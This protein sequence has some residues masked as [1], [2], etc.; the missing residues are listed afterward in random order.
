LEILI[1]LINQR[2]QELQWLAIIL[3]QR[4]YTES[5]KNFVNRL[6]A[7]WQIWQQESEKSL[8]SQLVTV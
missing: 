2:R 6:G 8:V 3:G 1:S 5:P 4:I 7:Y